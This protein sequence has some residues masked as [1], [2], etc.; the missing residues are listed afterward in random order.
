MGKEGLY[1]IVYLVIGFLFGLLT[2]VI[3][4]NFEEK[5][6]SL[7][8]L[9]EWLS[10]IEEEFRFYVELHENPRRSNWLWGDGRDKEIVLKV[11]RNNA[12]MFGLF[13][14][15]SVTKKVRDAIE[16]VIQKRAQGQN[17]LNAVNSGNKTPGE[18]SDDQKT[19]L[20]FHLSNLTESIEYANKII[21]DYENNAFK[22]FFT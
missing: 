16:M 8:L 20:D 9:K 2:S 17:I 6:Q 13:R 21:V 10:D 3:K 22:M 18:I 5:K 19:K 4:I 11:L 1:Q 15:K 7:K 14:S 12:Q